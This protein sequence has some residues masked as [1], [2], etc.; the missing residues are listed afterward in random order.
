MSDDIIREID[1]IISE[2]KRRELDRV[3]EKR[4]VKTEIKPVKQ[5][6]KESVVLDTI[7]EQIESPMTTIHCREAISE[8]EL[9]LINKNPENY[10]EIN[11]IK[12]IRIVDSFY[13]HSNIKTFHYDSYK[14]SIIEE[15]IYILPTKKGFF[16]PTCFFRERVE[17]PVDYIQKNMGISGKALSLLYDVKLYVDLFS[18]EE[19]K[20]NL[21]IVLLLI[22]SMSCYIIGLYFNLGGTI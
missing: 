9:P 12:D 14:Y 20:Y 13:I 19:G 8:K 4:E 17:S 18:G 5:E 11:F 15:R 6:V 7:Q 1:K 3:I 21:F 2:R 16:I 22:A 10:I